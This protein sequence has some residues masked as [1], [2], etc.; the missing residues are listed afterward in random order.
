VGQKKARTKLSRTA[1]EDGGR[2]VNMEISACQAVAGRTAIRC[3]GAKNRTKRKGGGEETQDR[4]GARN[5][6]KRGYLT[7][8]GGG[9]TNAKR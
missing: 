3:S 4:Y 9:T 7:E 1:H 2:K 5:A 6:S 8:P